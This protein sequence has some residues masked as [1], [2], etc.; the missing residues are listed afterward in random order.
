MAS[1]LALSPLQAQ[2]RLAVD[3]TIPRDTLTAGDG[4]TVEAS[5]VLQ[6]AKTIELLKSGFSA[7]LHYRLE[8]WRKGTIWDSRE[9]FAEWDVLV[10]Y[11]PA[12]NLYRVY[13]KVG[14]VVSELGHG[15]TLARAEELVDRPHAVVIGPTQPG[16]RYYYVIHL[17]LTSLSGSDLDETLRWLQG[18]AAPA[19]HGRGNPATAIKN[20]LESLFSKLL[21]RHETYDRPSAL[22]IA[23]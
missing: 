15:S 11:E 9:R 7:R 22:F 6:D 8:L 2:K 16:K 19:V 10:D 14:T 20:G 23:G 18:E 3:I 4:P 1:V 17:D 5:N 21:G 12:Q 13:R